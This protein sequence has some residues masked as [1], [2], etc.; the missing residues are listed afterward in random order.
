MSRANITDSQVT[1]LIE[2]DGQICAVRMEKEKLE[3]ITMLA[4]T[5]V[6]ELIKTNVTQEELNRFLLPSFFE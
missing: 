4:K 3:A 2:V 6:D 1:I 5:S